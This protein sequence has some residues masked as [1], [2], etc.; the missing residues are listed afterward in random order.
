MSARSFPEIERAWI[1]H[2]P[3]RARVPPECWRRLRTFKRHIAPAAAK[4]TRVSADEPV[5]RPLVTDFLFKKK[6]GKARAMAKLKR[7]LAPAT[8]TVSE[9]GLMWSWLEPRGPLL[10]SD[11][12]GEQQ[13]CVLVNFGTTMRYGRHA[14]SMVAWSLE[15]PDHSLGR[16]LQR[17]PHADL[18]EVLHQA[19]LEFLLADAD[20][21]CRE[22]GQSFYLRAG[23]GLFICNAIYAKTPTG[24]K[25]IYGRAQTWISKQQA[26]PDQVPVAPPATDNDGAM[27]MG[28]LIHL[29]AVEGEE[30]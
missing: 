2:D 14:A 27:S 6:L 13:D 22:D 7:I 17:S 19:H 20:Q 28:R 3:D 24:Q 18:A 21:V 25:F 16:L 8:F 10:N 23:Q 9:G 4:V 15:L 12:P 5:L 1:A 26:R 29:A 30:P 11:R